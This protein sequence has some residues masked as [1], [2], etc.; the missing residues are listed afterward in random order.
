MLGERE[1]SETMKKLPLYCAR[2]L[3]ENFV[4]F[5]RRFPHNCRSRDEHKLASSEKLPVVVSA[6]FHTTRTMPNETR[7]LHT[8]N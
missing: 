2:Q 3:A 8:L 5:F 7:E 1:A 4:P 6:A